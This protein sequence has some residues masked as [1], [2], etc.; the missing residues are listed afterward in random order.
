[1]SET[2]GCALTE[3]AAEPPLEA[4]AEAAADVVTRSYLWEA[5]YTIVLVLFTSDHDHRSFSVRS[6]SCGSNTY[7][8]VL[9]E[10]S[11]LLFGI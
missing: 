1:M 5:Y 10:P 4:A 3:S 2:R 6:R 9:P 8:S 11:T 7:H